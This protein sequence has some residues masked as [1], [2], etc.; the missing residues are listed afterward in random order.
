MLTHAR[1]AAK[2]IETDGKI[3]ILGGVHP[4][5][6]SSALCL[7]TK[8]RRSRQVD[9]CEIHH[10]AARLAPPS[11]EPPS[12]SAGPPTLSYLLSSERSTW[13]F[14]LQLPSRDPHQ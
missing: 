11:E 10:T 4:Q 5:R 2:A 14:C 1:Y 3:V 7:D 8:G 9:A 12:S 6:G 13:A